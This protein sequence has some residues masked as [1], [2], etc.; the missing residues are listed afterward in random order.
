MHSKAKAV[1]RKHKK[2]QRRAAEKRKEG[3]AI[4]AQLKAS[5][6]RKKKVELT[7]TV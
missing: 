5:R 6:S 3:L 4:Q 2:A 7:E 1:K